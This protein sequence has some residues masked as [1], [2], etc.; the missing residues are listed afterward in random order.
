[1]RTYSHLYFLNINCIYATIEKNNSKN[2]FYSM[3]N[4]VIINI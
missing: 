1:M 3:R 2:M 4:L